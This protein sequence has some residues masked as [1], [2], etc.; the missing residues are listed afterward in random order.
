M[1]Q[2]VKEI[3]DDVFMASIKGGLV[4]VDFWA[5]WC[6]PCQMMAP[7]LDKIAANATY[8]KFF[9]VDV[10]QHTASAGGL[11]VQS[12]PTFVLFKDGVEVDRLVGA[13]PEAEVIAFLEK[14]K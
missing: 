10:D 1:S 9:K 6:G 11:G 12:I 5:T 8:A 3:G 7:V 14:H 4:L 2:N 13:H